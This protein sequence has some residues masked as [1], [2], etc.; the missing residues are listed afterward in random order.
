MGGNA[1]WQAGPYQ[2]SLV[3]AFRQAQE[4]E[5]AKDNHGFEGRTIEELWQEEEWTKYILTGGT[6]TVLD[7]IHIV[8]PT[9]TAR[10]PFMRPLTDGEVRRWAP[11]GR[12]A[13]AEWVNALETERLSY[14]GRAC[15]NCTVLYRDGEPT[16]IGYWGV[17]AD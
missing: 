2:E 15:G 6:G 14:P 1:W 10:G 7:L 4:Q 11:S 12:P 17:T 3:A 16:E 8:H 9:D 13:H 5:L